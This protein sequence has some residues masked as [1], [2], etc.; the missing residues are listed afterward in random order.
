[1]K[2]LLIIE[3]TFFIFL[4]LALILINIFCWQDYLKTKDQIEIGKC[5]DRFGNEIIGEECLIKQDINDVMFLNTISI[6]LIIILAM[7]F[8]SSTTLFNFEELE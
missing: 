1:M 5:Y 8:N 3:K 4:I 6:I 7:F 2:I